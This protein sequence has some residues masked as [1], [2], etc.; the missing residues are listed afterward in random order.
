LNGVNLS[1]ANL[2]R[3]DLSWANLSS[4]NLSK[5]RLLGAKLNAADLSKAILIGAN[6]CG[7]ELHKANLSDANLNGAYM[8][9]AHLAEANF[10]RATLNGANLSGASLVDTKVTNA[11]FTDCSVY[12]ISAWNLV[13]EPKEQLNLHISRGEWPHKGQTLTVDNPNVAQFVYLLRENEKVRELLKAVTS[14]LVLI[15]GRFGE[16]RYVLDAIQDLFRQGTTYSP[17]IFDF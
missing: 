3:A 17:L 2:M 4:A 13:G 11:T 12:G 9:W 10:E 1:N 14:K 5:A 8:R 16:R 6:L 15:L 7:A